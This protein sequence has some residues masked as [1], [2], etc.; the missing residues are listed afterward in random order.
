MKTNLTTNPETKTAKHFV[1]AFFVLSIITFCASAQTLTTDQSDYPPGATAY[2]T[3]TGFWANEIVAIEV[4]HADG[5]PDTGAEHEPWYVTA[6]GNGDFV[7][8]W[9]VCED[10][11]LGALLRATA[12]GQ[13]SALYAEALFTDG[14]N[15]TYSMSVIPTSA[16][17]GVSVAHTITLFIDATSPQ[18][19]A[20]AEITVPSG[21]CTPTSVTVTALDPPL[22]P[23]TSRPWTYGGISAGR[24]QFSRSGGSGNDI[25]PGGKITITFSSTYSTT[26][27]MEWTTTAYKNNNYASAFDASTN[28]EP[29]VTVTSPCTSPSF[30]ACPS[31]TSVNTDVNLCT[32]A[33]SYTATA[34]G[35]P[36][37]ALTYT[38]SG[39]TTG[40]GAGTG[41]GSSFNKGITTV[42]I[43][44]T[45]TCG[46]PV[47]SFT[48]TVTDNQN[49]TIGCVSNQTRNTTSNACIYTAIGTEFNPSSFGD[50][51]T[52]ASVAYSLAGVTSGAG[53]SLAGVAFNKG[54]TTVS[55]KVTDASGNTATCSFSV[56]VNDNQ[57]PVITT[58]APA[59]DVNLD[60]SCELVVPDLVAQS[61]ATDNCT[62]TLTQS[63]LAGAALASS[64]N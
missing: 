61:T 32:K 50:N 53:S 2:L 30:T 33:V 21:A 1:I 9:H 54:L 55:W 51:C 64:H 22:T 46:S 63:P 14:P 57:S 40:S 29:E 45:N 39:A 19:C 15:G 12:T 49:P 28:G 44:A 10:D 56:T 23:G 20:S 26:G 35:S 58:C 62:Y 41:S 31:N 17:T 36:A 48:I 24:M 47:C 60:G 13:S 43:T 27:L 42:A 38:F 4:N 52:G 5:T 59:Q 7:T 25:D 34:I 8:T 6:D 18:N 11:C 3:G 37:P 16:N